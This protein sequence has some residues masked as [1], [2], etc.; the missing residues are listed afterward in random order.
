LKSST[1]KIL[2]NQYLMAANQQD[3]NPVVFSKRGRGGK[4]KTGERAATQARQH[5][6]AVQTTKKFEA[7]SNKQRRVGT[8]LRKLDEETEDFRH[9]Q[10]SLSMGKRIQQARL[11]KKWT[12]KDLAQRINEKSTVINDYENGRAIPNNQIIS[13]IE[14]ALGCQLRGGKRRVRGR[15]AK[16]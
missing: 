4:G 14:R 16:K 9:A 5:G 12:Q 3:W 6:Q 15:G 10:V 7:G 11:A 13:K 8:S 2:R 1:K